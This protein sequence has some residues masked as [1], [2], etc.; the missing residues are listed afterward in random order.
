MS[1]PPNH[2][3]VV[4]RL[5]ADAAAVRPLWPPGVRLAWWLLLDA[6][7][8]GLVVAVAPRPDLSWHLVQPLFVLQIAALLIAAAVVAVLALRGAVPGRV[9]SRAERTA[10]MSA[11]ALALGLLALDRPEPG[12]LA[13][14]V[15]RGGVCVASTLLL[16]VIP[17]LALFLAVRR[18]AP[19]AVRGVGADTGGAA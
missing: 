2:A 5:T 10:A 13:A 8:I 11:V 4:A 7:V 18:G 15:T 19:T 3:R 1:R 16:A 17:W 14:F 12:A 9:P 6:A